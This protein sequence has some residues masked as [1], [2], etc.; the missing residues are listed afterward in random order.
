[1]RIGLMVGREE[2]FPKAFI[3]RVNALG[4]VDVTAEFVVLGGTR[5]DE[6]CPYDV[7]I[8]RISHEV[9][10]YRTYLKQAALAGTRII[11]NPFRCAADD[12]HFGF[13]LAS[14]IGIAIPRTALLPNKDYCEGIVP[15]SLR[16]LAYPIDWQ[17]IVDYVGLPAFLKPAHGGG[18]KNVNKIETL[19][20]LLYHYDQSGQLTMTLQ[21]AVN[22]DQYVRC[23]CIGRE[24]VIIAQYDVKQRRYLPAEGYLEPA[25]EKR[26][27]ADT[28]T[29]NRALGYDM[30]TVEF[31]IENGV[32]Y[33]ID[34]T[35]TAPDMEFWSITDIYF[36]R[37]VDAMI[38]LALRL[39][40]EGRTK[41]DHL[42]MGAMTGEGKLVAK[43][44]APKAAAPTP[45]AAVTVAPAK[46]AVAT[47]PLPTA[48][49]AA[50]AAIVKP[51]AKSAEPVAGTPAPTPAPVVKSVEL[52]K[53]KKTKK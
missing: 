16:N 8:D 50:A 31:A 13:A 32:P 49:P 26:I 35:N 14:R 17:G 10:Y 47:A 6:E 30:N 39:G 46:P 15:E 24:E 51:V 29:I 23:W 4:K 7:I 37:V 22:F 53:A 36:D 42:S 44:V 45:L 1:M 33:A 48:A 52:P 40:E 11:N 21:Q 19:D 12:K 41:M 9:P 38:R 5:L 43:P 3:E 28:L 20:E 25:M 18:W 27:I 34:F 2:T